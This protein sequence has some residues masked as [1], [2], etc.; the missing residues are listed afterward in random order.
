MS[1]SFLY[2]LRCEDAFK[3]GISIDPNIRIKS[4][5]TSTPFE[6][7]VIHTIEID[8]R[9]DARIAEKI[10]HQQMTDLGMHIKL[11]WFR[12]EQSEIVQICESA[13]HVARHE[14]RIYRKSAEKKARHIAKIVRHEVVSEMIG[15]SE[16]RLSEISGGSKLIPH[17]TMRLNT[18]W[19]EIN[20]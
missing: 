3:V 14:G 16:E 15:I 8:G 9:D 6:V 20:G 12:G 2:I 19:G 4:I 1:K 11:E 17:E 18:L 10:A 13:A 7:H 5:A